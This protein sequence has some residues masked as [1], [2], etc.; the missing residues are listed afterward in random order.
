MWLAQSNYIAKLYVHRHLE[1]VW[2]F[3][4]TTHTSLRA[5]T[6]RGA[7]I[8]V[9]NSPTE[10]ASADFVSL[11]MTEGEGFLISP[12]GEKPNES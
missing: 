9:L 12:L 5:P 1:V 4:M 8:S 11:A 2:P 7:A 10:I 3:A 6:C